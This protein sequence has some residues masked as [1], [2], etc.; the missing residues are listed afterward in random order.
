MKDDFKEYDA[1]ECV[2]Y[3]VVNSLKT[4]KDKSIKAS[5]LLQQHPELSNDSKAY[6]EK[7]IAEKEASTFQGFIKSK[8]E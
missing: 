4:L 6:L 1:I 8:G 2:V 7:F 3:Y 5:E